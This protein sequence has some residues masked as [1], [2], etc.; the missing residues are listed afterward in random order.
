MR[1]HA[2]SGIFG[3]RLGVILWAI[4]GA[5]PALAQDVGI[6]RT[7]GE[8]L[9]RADAAAE[10]QAQWARLYTEL[11]EAKRVINERE[12]R[13]KAVREVYWKSIEETGEADDDIA[14]QYFALLALRDEYHREKFWAE[15]QFSAQ[16]WA[17]SLAWSIGQSGV[18]SSLPSFSVKAHE[19]WARSTFHPIRK[20][21]GNA[22]RH[23]P[24]AELKAYA[25]YLERRLRAEYLWEYQGSPLRSENPVLFFPAYLIGTG[26]CTTMD[27]V[28]AIYE[29]RAE[30]FGNEALTEA[31]RDLRAAFDYRL[32]SIEHSTIH[33]RYL[34]ALDRRLAERAPNHL[35]AF[36]IMRS[37]GLIDWDIALAMH[38]NRIERWGAETI[39]AGVRPAIEGYATEGSPDYRAF[40]TSVFIFDESA[41]RNGRTI[42]RDPVPT[43]IFRSAA[44]GIFDS[45]QRH[46]GIKFAEVDEI[47]SL[48]RYVDVYD[49][50]MGIV[51]EQGAQ[52]IIKGARGTNPLANL[53]PGLARWLNED[54]VAGAIV[55]GR[56]VPLKVNR[57]IEFSF[58]EA[59][60]ADGGA[61]RDRY[62]PVP[63]L[64]L[65]ARIANDAE[66]Y[67]AT[68]TGAELTRGVP[69]TP[70]QLQDALTSYPAWRERLTDDEIQRAY[71]GIVR[72][73]DHRSFGVP[74]LRGDSLTS[75]FSIRK[76]AL[77]FLE[78]GEPLLIT[79]EAGGE[80][81][82]MMSDALFGKR[83]DSRLGSEFSSILFDI[84]HPQLG[85]AGTGVIRQRMK[86][87]LEPMAGRAL[88]AFNSMRL[89]WRSYI[90]TD[91]ATDRAAAVESRAALITILT[92]LDN[93][94]SSDEARKLGYKYE[95]LRASRPERP[96]DAWAQTYNFI[97]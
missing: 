48:V 74:H 81:Q 65:F 28:V 93:Y 14:S 21:L 78:V 73:I 42:W 83:V 61:Y 84:R 35:P 50:A 95:V 19:D 59:L 51:E 44:E 3:L 82:A 43:A 46:D 30:L 69:S 85:Y 53:E 34:H 56:H 60:R 54:L 6:G 58:D 18:D 97:R 12:A 90:A 10:Q 86:P 37:H 22:D 92:E 55:A 88:E 40:D 23:D 45:S 13:L 4:A 29:Q 9:M 47:A 31:I 16:G 66:T 70:E 41:G 1:T 80:A 8:A 11:D 33:F 63:W 27:E 67:F 5:S 57:G 2:L 38:E 87:T 17:G 32:L 77:K 91:I 94:V 39:E 7:F 49:Y 72:F 64:Q 26:I 75:S 96:A 89:R 62:Y 68:A 71:A 15:G 79:T 20:L 24:E 76:H 52:S 36:F 25:H